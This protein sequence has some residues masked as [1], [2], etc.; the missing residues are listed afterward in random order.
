MESGGVACVVVPPDDHIVRVLHAP[1]GQ[2]VHPEVVSRVRSPI[3][4]GILCV[5]LLTFS[6]F[7]VEVCSRARSC[8]DLGE[9]EPC[10][11][12]PGLLVEAHGADLRRHKLDRSCVPSYGSGHN[13]PVLLLIEPI[14]VCEEQILNTSLYQVGLVGDENSDL[15]GGVEKDDEEDATTHHASLIQ[16]LAATN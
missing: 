13:E 8:F 11:I 3:E 5:G 10:V 9:G 16:I 2:A 7:V 12:A 14:S 4:R 15:V 1:H 6:R